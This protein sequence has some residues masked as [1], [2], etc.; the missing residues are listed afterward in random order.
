MQAAYDRVSKEAVAGIYGQRVVPNKDGDEEDNP[1][2]RPD[3][4]YVDD[5]KGYK[6]HF[7]M[8]AN[9]DNIREQGEEE[10]PPAPEA[11]GEE[12]APEAGAEDPGME[13]GVDP[14]MEAGMDPNDPNAGMP[15]MPG[16]AEPLTST[17]IGRMYEF[18]KIYSRL[19]SVETYLSRTTDESM[20]EIRKIVGQSIDLFEVVIS[21]FTQYKEK[22]DEIIVTY[23]E[24]LDSVYSSLRKYFAEMSKEQK[25]DRS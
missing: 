16:G 17:E 5:P 18:K 15:P 23:Y 24:F 2:T 25:N 22:V 4:P 13:G 10:A 12:M 8:E 1:D 3:F 11:G 9:A 19:A 21:N 7:P 20:L 6:T 14:G